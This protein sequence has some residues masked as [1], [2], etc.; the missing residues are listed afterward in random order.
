MA[1][2]ITRI[3]VRDY[4]TWKPMFDQ[5]APGARGGANWHRIFRNVDNPNEV[6]IQIDF[7]TTEDALAARDRLVQSG[8]LNRF[9]DYTGPTVVEEAELVENR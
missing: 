1:S 7:T 6:Y 8:V 9:D 2:I 5:D 3:D 4:D